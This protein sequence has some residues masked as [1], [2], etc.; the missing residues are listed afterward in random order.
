MLYCTMKQPLPNTF[1]CTAFKKY[2]SFIL[3]ENQKEAK[4]SKMF[5]YLPSSL[6]RKE[7]FLQWKGHL[8][9]HLMDVSYDVSGSYYKVVK[10]IPEVLNQNLVQILM[11]TFRMEENSIQITGFLG[12]VVIISK[13]K[14]NFNGLINFRLEL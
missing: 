9:L 4:F 10:N 1:D 13:E 11:V 6:D 8:Y 12:L 5:L 14:T 3:D 7:D 2:H